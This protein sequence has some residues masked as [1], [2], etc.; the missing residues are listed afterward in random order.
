MCNFEMHG[1]FCDLKATMCKKCVIPLTIF[2]HAVTS[3]T[4]M[5]IFFCIPTL[6][7]ITLNEQVSPCS[8]NIFNERIKLFSF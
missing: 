5:K 7:S 4:H 6:N 1:Q 8:R 3:L 2:L